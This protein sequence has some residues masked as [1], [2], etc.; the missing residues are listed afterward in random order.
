MVNCLKYRTQIPKHTE[1]AFSVIEYLNFIENIL[2]Y[3]LHCSILF[4]GN[5]LFFHAGE[6]SLYTAVVIRASQIA[7]AIGD[8]VFIQDA[9]VLGDVARHVSRI[10][11]AIV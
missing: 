3:C 2:L 7:H 9:L 6:E 4:P 11:C 10:S 8:M 5:I 1:Q